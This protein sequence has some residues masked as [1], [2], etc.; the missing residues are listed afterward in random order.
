MV[1]LILLA[2]V[3]SIPR[4]S[5]YFSNKIHNYAKN[6]IGENTYNQILKDRVV[7]KRDEIHF[8]KSIDKAY[9]EPSLYETSISYGFV[10]L[11]IVFVVFGIILTYYNQNEESIIGR[12]FPLVFTVFGLVLLGQYF[13]TKYI[14]GKNTL[15]IYWGMNKRFIKYDNILEV[16]KRTI[17]QLF[18]HR[19]KGR[20]RAE[21]NSKVLFITFIDS[22]NKQRI[23]MI[24]PKQQNE[25]IQHLRCKIDKR[26]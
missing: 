23:I 4:I 1:I 10:V 17:N 26:T 24:S 20:I 14:I 8:D 15:D 25:F 12:Y 7:F 3:I 9:K 19:Q 2:V 16:E 21:T 18:K 22:K 13:T 11:F 5:K 6:K